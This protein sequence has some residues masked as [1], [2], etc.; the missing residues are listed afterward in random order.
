MSELT[1]GDAVRLRAL[2]WVARAALRIR[3]PL[4]AKSIVDRV[5]SLFPRLHG[6]EDAHAAVRELFPAGSCLS[7][8]LAIAATVPGAEVVIGVY[9]P[10][11]S[12]IVAHAWL[13]IDAVCVDTRP[14]ESGARREH[15]RG[16]GLPGELTRLA[17][18]SDPLP[19][20]FSLSDFLSYRK[21]I[22]RQ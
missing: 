1:A 14:A 16:S 20:S 6:V 19:D 8:A 15:E 17:G 21:Q 3:S 9:P 12:S 4:R 13:E 7:R 10:S 2:H 5:A 18:R 22:R 11:Q